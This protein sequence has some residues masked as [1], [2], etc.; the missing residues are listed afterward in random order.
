[1]MIFKYYHFITFYNILTFVRLTLFI[2]TV[3]SLFLDCTHQCFDWK[4]ISTYKNNNNNNNN[5]CVTLQSRN[6][7]F[8]GIEYREVSAQGCS[9]QPTGGVDY[10]IFLSLFLF[11][12]KF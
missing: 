11:K 7:S 5:L 4:N 10:F 3:I 2:Y 8:T 12:V 9:V 1:M 6:C